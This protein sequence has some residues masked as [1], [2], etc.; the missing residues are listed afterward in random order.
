M[1]DFTPTLTPIADH[2]AELAKAELGVAKLAASR[3]DR[4]Y[5]KFHIASNGGWI[6]APH[7]LRHYQGPWYVFY[8]LHPLRPPLVPML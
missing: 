7:R 6:N 5:P 4:W 1:S 2:D 8:P 3:N